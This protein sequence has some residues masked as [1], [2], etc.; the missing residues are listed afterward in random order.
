MA[1]PHVAGVAAQIRALDPSITP[2][3]VAE[4]ISCLSTKG[5]LSG[6]PSGGDTVNKLLFNRFS[7]DTNGCVAPAPPASPSPP[8]SPPKSPLPPSSPPPP[9][10]KCLETCQ[11]NKDNNPLACLKPGLNDET[12][13]WP[14]MRHERIAAQCCTSDGECRRK[15]GPGGGECVAGDSGMENGLITEFTY[16]KNEEFCAEKGLVMCKRSCKGGG[17][18]YNRHPV[19]SSI[20]CPEPP[21][22]TPSPPSPPP[23]SP[24]AASWSSRATR[25][26]TNRR[27][28]ACTP[29][30]TTARRSGP[31]LACCT[32]GS[33]RSAA[34]AAP[35]QMRAAATCPGPDAS[36][37]PPPTLWAVSSTSSRTRRMR[38]SARRKAS[39]CASNPAKA[40]GASTTSTPSLRR[41]RATSILLILSLLPL[42]LRFLLPLLLR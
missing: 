26:R 4:A 3:E 1:C 27:W 31:A 35:A 38:S 29:A 42:L 30:S 13:T 15:V 6:L 41:C 25:T 14:G 7:E 34:P 28:A 18:F 10:G 17:C 19:F 2:A 12:M 33:P 21:S 5:A 22:T 39:S 11:Y 20:P 36:P 23:A 40:G 8:P 16:A 24:P 32:T 9:P 37:V